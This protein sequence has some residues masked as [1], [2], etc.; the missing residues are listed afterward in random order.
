MRRW[1]AST[2][3]EPGEVLELVDVAMPEPEDGEALVRV[4]VAGVALPDLMMVRGQYPMA[5]SPPV[6]PGQ[7]VV[8]VVE[9]AGAGFPHP[10]GTR[11]VGN[12]RADIAVGG[13][14]EYTRVPGWSATTV[15]EGLTVEQ[16]VGFPGSFD[17][18]HIGLHHRAHLR[19]G[20]SVLVLGG[21]GR[22][23][24]AAIQVAK[25]M[26][27]HVIATA[28]TEAKA[29]FCRDQGAD[30]VVDLSRSSA[31]AT[32]AAATGGRGVDVV[33][34]TVGGQAYAD[35]TGLLTRSG[36][37]VLLVG[38]A[39]GSAARPDGNDL[40]MRDYSVM[41]VISAFRDDDERRRTASALATM[42]AAG[43]ITPPVTAVHPFDDVPRAIAQRGGDATGQTVITVTTSDTP[44]A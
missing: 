43:D 7:E 21:A 31:A 11:V 28:R 8:G 22:T 23:G 1:Q 12:S 29:R 15:P 30:E 24:S 10:V 34:D 42:L 35:A 19:A 41:G 17:V 18:A 26:G 25:A 13:L 37:R 9:R 4:L 6:S 20:E 5:P 38:Y 44:A 32:V 3:G 33:Y 27:A 16:A 36:G 40:I 2:F 39:S 14:A